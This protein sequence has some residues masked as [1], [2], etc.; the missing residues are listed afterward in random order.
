MGLL[1]NAKQIVLR[2]PRAGP[3][4]FSY[5]LLPFTFYYPPATTT[6]TEMEAKQLLRSYIF[7]SQDPICRL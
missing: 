5:P 4:S 6:W 2:G 1:W 7:Q 3:L